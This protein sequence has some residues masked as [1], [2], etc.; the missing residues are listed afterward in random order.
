[1]QITKRFLQ[2]CLHRT[3]RWIFFFYILAA[4]SFTS[5][6]RSEQF[7]AAPP[8]TGVS[9]LQLSPNCPPP[10]WSSA[11]ASPRSARTARSRT[12]RRWTARSPPWSPVC[13]IAS[14]CGRCFRSAWNR[15]ATGLWPC[16][17]LQGV[18]GRNKPC[19]LSL[20]IHTPLDSR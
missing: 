8:W 3:R 13:S 7:S 19:D 17:T 2:Y 4:P 10:N 5:A 6:Q 11:A 1:M 16:Y 18:G 9:P 20:M 14:Q 15:S 12:S